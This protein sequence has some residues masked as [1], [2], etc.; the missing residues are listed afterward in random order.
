MPRWLWVG[1]DL[2]MTNCS[3]VRTLPADCGVRGSL[4]LTGCSGLR[5]LPPML[6]VDECVSSMAAPA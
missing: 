6:S 3:A 1:G 4:D 2:D 5:S